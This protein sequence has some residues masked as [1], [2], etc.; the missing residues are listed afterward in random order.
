MTAL[1][2]GRPARV[3]PCALVLGVLLCISWLLLL[4]QRT[5]VVHVSPHSR[6]SSLSDGSSSSSD[7]AA[8][9]TERRALRERLYAQSAAR[10]QGT[11]D[12]A[13][14]EGSWFR[15]QCSRLPYGFLLFEPLWRWCEL[16]ATGV[17]GDGL[18]WTCN[19][20]ELLRRA[21]DSTSGCVVYSCGSNENDVFERYIV[22]ELEPRCEIHTWDPTSRAIRSNFHNEYGL[23]A[24]GDGA[25]P[26]HHTGGVRMATRTLPSIMQELGHDH[27]DI[28][29]VDVEGME[30]AVVRQLERDGWPSIGQ[31]LMEVHYRN[32]DQYIGTMLALERAGFRLFSKEKNLLCTDCFEYSWIH[33][34]LVLPSGDDDGGGS[35]YATLFN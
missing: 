17:T 13:A 25:A 6:G 7:L 35:T 23:G 31:V 5:I 1:Q 18:K 10:R 4:Q 9:L 20:R 12:A 21:A 24:G 33:S 32:L 8:A 14:V 26:G 11:L 29:K 15:K 27:I 22:T 28:L 30:H 16:E 2:Q 19:A 34:S 3:T